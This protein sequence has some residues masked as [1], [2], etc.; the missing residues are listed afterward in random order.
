MAKRN[1]K[2]MNH[3]LAEL[4][5]IAIRANL[6]NYDEDT[7]EQAPMTKTEVFSIFTKRDYQEYF[8]NGDSPQETF[9]L[10]MDGWQDAVNES[11]RV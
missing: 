3:W 6:F 2:N 1:L 4:R 5:E 11:C 10:T 7:K 8:E 9:D